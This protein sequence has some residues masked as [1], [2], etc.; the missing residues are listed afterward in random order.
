MRV[1]TC[2]RTATGRI[3]GI[4]GL[5]GPGV[6][7]KPPAP[8]QETDQLAEGSRCAALEAPRCAHARQLPHQ[9]PE[10]E[11]ADV[12]EQTFQDIGMPAQM[13]VAHPAGRV[14]VGVGPFQK[15]AALPQEPVPARAPRMRRRF[16][17][18]A[19]RAAALP[20]Q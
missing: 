10:I 7:Q 17:Y 20:V 8:G 16:A 13:H 2:R 6:T 9:Q 19:F 1:L 12:H 3:R 5:R 14:E 15:L 11:A 18:T 4:S